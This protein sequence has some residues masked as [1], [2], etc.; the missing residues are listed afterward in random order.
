[1]IS[2][3]APRDDEFI[4]T[5]ES[6]HRLT[7]RIS[8]HTFTRSGQP[9]RSTNIRPSGKVTLQFPPDLDPIAGSHNLSEEDRR[10]DF[11]PCHFEHDAS[12]NL[13]SFSFMAGNGRVAGLIGLPRPQG[14]LTARLVDVGNGFPDNLLASNEGKACI[15][16]GT[17]I[18][19][20]LS[21][22][23][24]RGWQDIS[25]ESES[26]LMCSIRGD[27]FKIIEFFL[28]KQ[29]LNVSDW[30]S[31][32]IFIT[33]GDD[34][35]GL[36]AGK[37]ESWWRSRFDSLRQQFPG[38]LEFSLGRMAQK[39]LE[40]FLAEASTDILFCGSKSLEWQIKMWS[41]GRAAVHCTER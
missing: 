37:P 29:I 21:L 39:D 30:A 20:F 14:Q 7:P 22:A 18:A 13:A 27:D 41:L 8:L 12:G 35:D 5:L 19:C 28:E 36:T 38:P 6:S 1:M 25:E 32:R 23:S 4:W 10:L 34:V 24:G 33:S 40:P 17:G 15:A 11:T 3:A 26:T 31:V 9:G 2:M 16:G